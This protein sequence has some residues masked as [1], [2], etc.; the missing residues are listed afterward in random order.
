MFS[1]L[2]F[3]TR[4]RSLAASL[5]VQWLRPH[6][7]MQGMQVRSLGVLR[8]H[9]PK[10]QNIK[11]KQHFNKFSKEL[12]KLSTSKN[13]QTKQ[14]ESQHSHTAV[15]SKIPLPL[16]LPQMKQTLEVAASLSVSGHLD[17]YYLFLNIICTLRGA[18]CLPVISDRIP[19]G[20]I[21]SFS[22]P[23][24]VNIQHFKLETYNVIYFWGLM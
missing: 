16:P 19:E 21:L 8:S 1:I 10:N 17:A 6:L 13:K 9:M 24:G 5:V 14:T 18:L 20:D 22:L 11:Q 2:S 3:Y 15:G 4:K 7:P 12:Q 23:T